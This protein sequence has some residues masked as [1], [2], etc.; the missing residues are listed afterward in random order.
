MKI[1]YSDIVKRISKLESPVS[2]SLANMRE[3]RIYTENKIFC[4]ENAVNSIRNWESLDK[5]TDV[6]FNKALDIFEELCMN[7]NESTIKESCR[8]LTEAE[9]KVRD[10]TQLMRSL[11]NR[12]A[13]IKHKTEYNITKAHNTVT[14]NI[15]SSISNLQNT[16][17]GASGGIA[18]A[19]T[20]NVAK[21]CFQE[22]EDQCSLITECDRILRNYATISRRFNLDKVVSN[23]YRSSDSYQ[24]CFEIASYIDT[25]NQPF[26]NRYNSALEMTAYLFDKHF[27]NYPKEMIVEAVTDYFL[28]TGSLKEA[29]VNDVRDVM[30]ISVLFEQDD[31]SS[32]SW[33]EMDPEPIENSVTIDLEDYGGEYGSIAEAIGF[34]K[35]IRDKKK[36]VKKDIKQTKKIIK[37]AAKEGNPE[38]HRDAEVKQ[39]VDDFRSSCLKNKDS[40][41]N[42]PSF[43][44]MV[45]KIFTKSPYQIVYE[46]PNILSLV[47]VVFVIGTGAIHPVLML[48]SFIAD[49]I[50]HI[51]L[52]RKQLEKIVKAYNSEIESVKAKT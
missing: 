22:L 20:V 5:D 13:R 10:Q 52:S 12:F 8:I 9:N 29:Q 1:S 43:K 4:K 25:Y 15:Y 3:A 48:C 33:L 32:L 36:E 18:K 24:A 23:I 16:L 45:S 37:R 41:T 35:I 17:K 49:Q 28:F 14:S 7:A 50:I 51:H 11:K 42:L 34:K 26:K 47:R 19:N 21:E 46:L 44:A 38:E 31:F 2:S 6:A 39:M 27:M 30:N 40:K